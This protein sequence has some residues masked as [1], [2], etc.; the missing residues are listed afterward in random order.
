MERHVFILDSA[1][2]PHGGDARIESDVLRGHAE[3]HE[4]RLTSDA[5]L[6]GEPCEIADAIIIWHELQLTYAALERLR[7]TRVIVRNGVG[8]DNV[9]IRGAAALGIAVANVPDYGTEEVADHT[10]ALTLALLR[11][12][13]PLFEDVARGAWNWQTAAACRRLR[14]QVFGIVGC[15][16]IGTAA[17]L[18][19]KA[20][21]FDVR[22]YDPY[23]PSGY[24]KAIGVR[25]EESLNAL[26]TEADVLSLHLPLTDET[27]FLIDI[28]QLRA[29]KPTAVVVNTAR[30]AV[31]R[32][33]AIDRALG[34][35]WIA[36]AALDVLENEPEG[37]DL[38]ARHPNCLVTPHSA[39]YSQESMEDLRRLSAV[40]VREALEGR[41]LN[42]VNGVTKPAAMAEKR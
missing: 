11:R 34:D 6:T 22:F 18:R 10:I 40:V 41:L 2:V 31:I 4:L 30:G 14:G 13:R 35:S 15:G 16:R 26:I 32:H 5:E 1:L 28:P 20:L 38:F 21:G 17:A 3:V 9:D 37:L 29:M 19:A 24:E 12:L 27:R 39:F 42:V 25:R 36:G 23:V 33:A 8:Y 7:K